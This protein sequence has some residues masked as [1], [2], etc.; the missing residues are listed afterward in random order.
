MLL[1]EEALTNVTELIDVVV[2]GEVLHS[3]TVQ[4]TGETQMSVTMTV[5]YDSDV[6]GDG[7]LGS[8]QYWL[9]P[10]ILTTDSDGDGLLD[11]LELGLG[12]D[13]FSYDTDMT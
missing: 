12:L 11:S 8:R 10:G 7:I 13:I 9:S 6:N 2:S 1:P 3:A 4:N 5:Q